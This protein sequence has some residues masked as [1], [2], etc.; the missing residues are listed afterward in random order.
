MK[1]IIQTP[2]LKARKTLLDFML[3]K[4]GKLEVLSDKIIESRIFLKLDK[5]G[6]RGNKVCEIQLFMPGH[7]LFASSHSHSF[8]G[9]VL[10]ATSAV[11]GQMERIKSLS[12]SERLN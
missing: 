11:K 12:R 7:E 9:A 8:E 1:T 4:V 2:H 10:Q 3:E 6:S 5:S